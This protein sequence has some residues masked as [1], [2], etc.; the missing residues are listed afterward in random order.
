MTI[1]VYTNTNRHTENESIQHYTINIDICIIASHPKNGRKSKTKMKILKPREQ[2]IMG[3]QSITRCECIH[4]CC[5]FVL[6]D[7]AA[8]LYI[9]MDGYIYL[10]ITP[11][12]THS[13]GRVG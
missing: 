7:C 4:G 9:N 12:K 6:D 2:H 13:I 1:N 3:T 10:K 5:F 11:K 8:S